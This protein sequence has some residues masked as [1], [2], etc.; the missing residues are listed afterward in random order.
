MVTCRLDYVLESCLDI[1]VRNGRW[2]LS[3]PQQ[4]CFLG[5]DLE[6]CSFLAWLSFQ[7]RL[8][9]GS[10]RFSFAHGTKLERQ[11]LMAA[12]LT[13]EPRTAK[14]SSGNASSKT[15]SKQAGTQLLYVGSCVCSAGAQGSRL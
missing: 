4:T 9:P 1:P 11:A 8:L 13:T 2:K 7:Q 12:N 3:L 14:E 6:N 15:K 10:G 5:K